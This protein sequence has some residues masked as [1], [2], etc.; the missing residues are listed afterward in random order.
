MSSRK[1]GLAY[2]ETGLAYFSA[3]LER[4]KVKIQPKDLFNAMKS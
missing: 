3:Q 4:E 1:T 2:L